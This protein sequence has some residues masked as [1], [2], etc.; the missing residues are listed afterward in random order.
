M[1]AGAKPIEKDSTFTFGPRQGIILRDC[2]MLT[3]SDA[4]RNNPI[5]AKGRTK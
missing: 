3:L 4:M 2:D 5:K 1:L